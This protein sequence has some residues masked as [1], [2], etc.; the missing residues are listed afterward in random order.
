MI[1]L[2]LL[3]GKH[4]PGFHP[5]FLNFQRCYQIKVRLYFIFFSGLYLIGFHTYRK[6]LNCIILPYFRTNRTILADVKKANVCL[7]I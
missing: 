3:Y 1:Q 4:K 2:P 7:K 6:K 5:S